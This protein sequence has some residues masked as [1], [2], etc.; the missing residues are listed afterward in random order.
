[1]VTSTGAVKN[2]KGTFVVMTRN[3][4]GSQLGKRLGLA[5]I[6]VVGMLLM[7][8]CSANEVFFL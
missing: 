1:M 8:G 3:S 7:S 5:G 2:A 4:T 6:A